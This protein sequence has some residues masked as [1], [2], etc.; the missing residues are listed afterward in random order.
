MYKPWFLYI[1]LAWQ[2][3][4]VPPEEQKTILIQFDSVTEC[5]SVAKQVD[6]QVKAARAVFYLKTISC[7]AC[8]EVLSDTRMCSHPT[9]KGK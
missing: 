4:P 1:I 9:K 6:T 5:V 3:T 8:N 2:V 7:R